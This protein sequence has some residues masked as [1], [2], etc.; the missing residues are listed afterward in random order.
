MTIAVPLRPARLTATHHLAIGG[1]VPELA[2]QGPPL[3]ATAAQ[4]LRPEFGLYG[5]NG[6]IIRHRQPRPFLTLSGW[7]WYGFGPWYRSPTS[8]RHSTPCSE[9]VSPGCAPCSGE[10]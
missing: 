8:P 5:R 7:R 3:R 4:A 6:W 10:A 2:I 1:E 9:Q